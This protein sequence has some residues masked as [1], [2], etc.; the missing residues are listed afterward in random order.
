MDELTKLIRAKK[1]ASDRIMARHA[2]AGT[3]PTYKMKLRIRLGSKLADNLPS[4]KT[5]FARR[6]LI[7]RSRV[8]GKMLCDDY[9]IVLTASRFKTVEKAVEFGLALQTTIAVAGSVGGL[10]LDVGA[11]NL[12]TTSF[13]EHV[14]EALA[15]AGHFLIDDVHGIDVY[16]DAITGIT[17]SGDVTGSSTFAS[18][19]LFN[20]MAKIGPKEKK[21][22]EKARSA[23]LMMNAAMLAPHPVA[24][25]ALSIGAVEQL[26]S[27]EKWTPAQRAWIAKTVPDFLE[28]SS[29]LSTTEKDELRRAV[30]GML[31]FG[32]SERVR[33]LI[34]RLGLSS[35]KARWKALY[36]KRSKLVHGDGDVSYSDLISMQGEARELSKQIV[37]AYIEG[38]IGVAIALL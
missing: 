34:D 29:G 36:D 23:A 12:A 16:P 25:I 27:G 19:R 15:K 35:I 8:K 1:E 28:R 14:K 30:G 13:S 3:T 24:A 5:T 22:D 18:Q 21:L 31:K 4:L 17:M 11:D 9:W 6:R 2:A 32:V 20:L 7:V 37:D 26:A 33:R 38:R 10:A